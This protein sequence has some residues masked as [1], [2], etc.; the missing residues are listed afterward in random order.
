MNL[1]KD[2]KEAIIFFLILC[3]C[4]LI[5]S[6]IIHFLDIRIQNDIKMRM[7]IFYSKIE[8]DYNECK[9]LKEVF[10]DL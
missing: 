7:K 3:F 9:N 5:P 10:D 8:K 2:I 4:V 1:N 6:F